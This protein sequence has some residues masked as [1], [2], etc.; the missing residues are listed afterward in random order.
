[1]G[2][3]RESVERVLK[4]AAKQKGY[5]AY[6]VD[7]DGYYYGYIITPRDNVLAV[8]NAEFWGAFISLQ[9]VPS[10]STGSGCSCHG[11]GNYGEH[12]VLDVDLDKLIALE[13][14]GLRYANKL[15]AKRYENSNEWLNHYWQKDELREVT[16]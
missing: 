15:K 8:S 11:N 2:G 9:Y 12:Y 5:K 7:K 13:D 1:M 4:F 10:R 14:E 16:A 3:Q 6:V